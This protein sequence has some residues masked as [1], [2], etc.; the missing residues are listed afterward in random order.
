[1]SFD[2]HYED[3]NLGTVCRHWPNKPERGIV[4]IETRA[5]NQNRERIVV[6]RRRYMFPKRGGS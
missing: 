4:A 2:R 5:F 3:F 1:M 6:L